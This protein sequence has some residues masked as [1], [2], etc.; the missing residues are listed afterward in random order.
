MWNAYVRDNLKNDRSSGAG[1]AVCAFFCALMLSLLCGLLYNMWSYDVERVKA[2]WGDV[3]G[4][5]D[6]P[7]SR[8]QLSAME[9]YDNVEAV[10]PEWG[11]GAELPASEKESG[12]TAP[13]AAEG[14]D[15][16]VSAAGIRLKWPGTA[17]EDFPRLAAL[18]GLGPEAVEYNEE[19]LDLYFVPNPQNPDAYMV[20]ILFLGAAALACLSLILIIR[21][22][23][24]VYMEERVQ[25]IGILASVGASPRQIRLCLLEEAAGLCA[26]P[27]AA[28]GLLGIGACAAAIQ[29]INAFAGEQ[30]PGRRDAVFSYH[31]LVLG[32]S[33]LCIA[34][35][36]WTSAWLPARALGRTT[37][38]AAIRGGS[39][40]RREARGRLGWRGLDRGILGRKGLG[41]GILGRREPGRGMGAASSALGMAFA[42]FILVQ[43]F[44]SLSEASTQMTY[45]DRY[46]EAWDVMVTVENTDIGD[47][48]ETQAVKGLAGVRDAAVYQKAPARRL[49]PA[50][51]LSGEFADAGG[52]LEESAGYVRP[53]GDGWSVGASLVILDD[54]SFLAFC[55]QIGA[56]ECL[57]GLV[58]YNQV[59]DL[60]NPNFREP[61][62][63][64]YVKEETGTAILA[65]TGDEGKQVQAEVLAYTRQAPLLRDDFQAE[66]YDDY[67]MVHFLPVSLWRQLRGTLGEGGAQTQVRLLAQEGADL[68][69]LEQIEAEALSVLSADGRA[70]AA[71]NRIGEQQASRRA[72]EALRGILGAFCV[73]LALIGLGNVF[74]TALGFAEKRGREMALYLSVGMT[75]GEIGLLFFREALLLVVRPLAF[76][77]LASGLLIGLFMRSA[78][79]E[80][81]IFWEN[82]PALPVGVFVL[83][84]CAAVGAAYFMGYRRIFRRSLGEMLRMSGRYG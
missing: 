59:R 65:R 70:A 84:V 50:D 82:A 64:P 46:A 74:V 73:M 49:L 6:G 83:G 3:H 29:W 1:A 66:A 75:P 28:G 22:A 21:S 20:L 10:V 9:V 26:L 40:G 31:P 12:K 8:E 37:P 5:I 51:A 71:E 15:G 55:R 76:A 68:Q 47:F 16:T 27:A 80:P 17:Y 63:L 42:A 19:L 39:A 69:E 61:S 35:T 54:E 58:V 23:F 34:I 41:R 81:G 38:L 4:R 36:L 52:F 18:A 48:T 7:L 62:Y 33:L 11:S 14:A 77:L 2:E 32:V 60:R 72:Q 43:S 67:E 78:Y 25:R 53:Y 44:L 57:D 56:P 24:A 13:P 30:V 79:L 45:F